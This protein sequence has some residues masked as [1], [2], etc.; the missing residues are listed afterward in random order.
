MIDIKSGFNE[1]I[2]NIQTWRNRYNTKEYPHKVVINMMY[3]AYGM[4]Y[5]WN[6]FKIAKL[7]KFQS[8]KDAVQGMET[9]Y[10]QVSMTQIRDNLL[11]WL[12]ES[13]TTPVGTITFANYERMACEAEN[14]ATKKEEL[15]F[16]YIFELLEDKLVLYYIGIRQ[17]GKSM[18]DTI[19][20]MTNYFIEPIPN[21]DY[22]M[23]KQV[24][25]QLYVA[26]FMNDNYIPLP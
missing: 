9:Y 10:A 6:D 21:M 24:F 16:S 15:E 19:A 17:T 3:R 20:L 14:N 22:L 2:R 12:K 25:Q 7:P 4:Q 26:K 1:A 11:N 8:I 18:E 23:A 5:I 13:P